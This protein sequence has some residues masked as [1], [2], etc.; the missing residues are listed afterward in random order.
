L[1]PR[2]SSGPLQA[3]IDLC[4]VNRNDPSSGGVGLLMREAGEWR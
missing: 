1:I 4:P 2:R 3:Q